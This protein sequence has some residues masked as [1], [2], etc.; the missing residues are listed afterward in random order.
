MYLDIYHSNLFSWVT[1]S[2]RR[3][4][5]FMR[6][7]QWRV[8]NALKRNE[9][10]KTLTSWNFWTAKD[11]K[12]VNMD[13][14]FSVFDARQS[15]WFMKNGYSTNQKLCSGEN[16]KYHSKHIQNIS[17]SLCQRAHFKSMFNYSQSKN[18]AMK[19]SLNSLWMNEK[20]ESLSFRYF[21][22]IY[23]SKYVSC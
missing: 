15:T 9:T 2:V 21:W 5:F 10:R 13:C 19:S 12:L 20:S 4:S 18:S 3:M 16:K 8:I 23:L 1:L 7:L 11:K 14:V 6:M 22:D 17:A